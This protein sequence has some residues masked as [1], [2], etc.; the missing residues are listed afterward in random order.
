MRSNE[1]IHIAKSIEATL[2]KNY[3]FALEGIPEDSLKPQYQTIKQTLMEIIKVNKSA[4]FAYLYIKRNNKIY[5]LADSESPLSKDY[6]PPGQEYTEAAPGYFVPFESH[7]DFV[8][9]PVKDRWGKWISALIP[10]KGPQ[11]GKIVA[12]YAMDFDANSWN[13]SLIFEVSQSSVLILLLLI[14]ILFSFTIKEKNISLKKEIAER[15]IAEAEQQQSQKRAKLQRNAISKIA[16]SEEITQADTATAFRELT[17]EAALALETSRA[18]IWLFSDDKEELR[19]IN[20]FDG[21]SH[22]NEEMLVKQKDFPIY[23]ASLKKES[24]I[25][26]NDAQNDSRTIEFKDIYL[27]PKGITSMLDAGIYIEGDLVG[28][29]C[30][31]HIGNMRNWY[32]DEESFARTV[33]SIVSQIIAQNNRREAEKILQ[34]IIE[35]NPISIQIVDKNGCTLSVNGAYKSLFKTTPASDYSVFDDSQL[36]HQGFGD[37]LMRAK[38]GE[39]VYF[40]DFQYQTNTLD[41]EKDCIWIQMVIFPLNSRGGKPKR[42]ILMHENINRRKLAEQEL[43]VAK[44]HAEESDRLKSAFLAN[45]SHEIRTPMNGILGFAELLKES[46]LDGDKQQEYIKIIVDSGKRMLNIIN[47]IVDISKIESGQ[48]DVDITESNINKQLDY[49]FDFFRPEVEAKGMT[50][51]YSKPLKDDETLIKTDPEKLYAIL[52]NLVKNAIKYSDKGSIEFGYRLTKQNMLEFFVKDTGIGISEDMH[53]AIFERFIQAKGTDTAL[54]Q[55]AGLGLAITKAYVNMLGGEISV[56]SKKGKGSVF[57][58]TIPNDTIK[59]EKMIF[60][61][62][63]TEETALKSVD[64]LKILVVEDDETSGKLITMVVKK[65]ARETLR[66][67]NGAEAVEICKEIK[68]IDLIL[69]DIQMPLMNGYE[70]TT[71]IRKF[72]DKVII[73]AQTANAFEGDKTRALAN[74]FNDYISKPIDRTKIEGFVNQYFGNRS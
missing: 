47:D 28:V 18:S 45:M 27:A 48:M 62:R 25:N 13:N 50:L 1:V 41:G 55:G 39:I 60:E 74:G 66:A 30:F 46:S 33:A 51:S 7:N 64:D 22:S 11:T 24:R 52:I 56:E 31:E 19:C 44:N 16:S 5:I 32:P 71:E 40:P 38:K 29:V 36:I 54:R 6:S 3:I 9:E 65:F 8:T 17:K 4:R 12:V 72:N 15:E 10:V 63:E 23:F 34:D 73:I 37:H 58:F 49:I 26:A 14:S 57:Y 69:M 42:Y 61:T 2:Q 59:S 68:D 21:D 53:Q 70:A 43:I 20:L 67:R 35:K